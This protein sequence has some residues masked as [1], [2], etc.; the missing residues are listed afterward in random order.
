VN[1]RQPAMKY[2][3]VQIATP[4][5]LIAPTGTT[6]IINVWAIAVSDQPIPFI[7]R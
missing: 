4:R 7:R 1:K 3:D 6:A 5:R 2:P